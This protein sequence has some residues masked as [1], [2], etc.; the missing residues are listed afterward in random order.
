MLVEWGLRLLQKHDCCD[1]PS[2]YTGMGC[3]QKRRVG[4]AVCQHSRDGWGERGQGEGCN[5]KDCELLSK[6]FRKEG[7]SGQEINNST[8]GGNPSSWWC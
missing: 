5:W 2:C 8:S 3:G 1:V 6:S 7:S 4:W